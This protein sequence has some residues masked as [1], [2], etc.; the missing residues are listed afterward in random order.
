MSEYADNLVKLQEKVKIVA[1]EDI[2]SDN[3]VLLAK[4]GIELN[5]KICANI[6]KF[7]LLKPLENSIAIENQLNAKSIYDK[8]KG[9]ILT[10]LSINAMHQKIGDKTSLQKCC[11]RVEKFPLIQQKLTVLCIELPTVFDQA[12]QSAYL[13]Y[14]CALIERHEQQNI[15]EYFLAGLVHDIG[16]LHIN[17]KILQKEGALTPDEWSNIQAHPIIAYEILNSIDKFPKV[18]SR[19]VLEHHENLDGTGYPRKKTGQDLSE[20]G[21]LLSLL[22]NVIAIY[23]KKFKTQGRS[24]RS[25]IPVLQINMHSYFPSVSST[26]IGMLKKTPNLPVQSTDSNFARDVIEKSERKQSYIQKTTHVIKETNKELG[27]THNNKD[28]HFIQ[29]AANNIMFIVNSAGLYGSFYLDEGEDLCQDEKQAHYNELADT[30][31]MLEEII[32]QCQFYEKTAGIFVAG[33]PQNPL[34][35]IISGGL[36]KI[37]ALS[38][39]RASGP[40]KRSRT[41]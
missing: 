38:L 13:A 21:Q 34:A 17:H 2:L 40:F 1:T 39:P 12:I 14:A 26:I 37:K 19:A 28:I 15:E 32:Y 31:V 24:L 8:V 10:N 6:L 41:G 36:E 18:V 22:D 33:N 25:V 3:G 29:N 5:K 16:F 11:L 35:K 4:S 23:S 7:K 27:F 30:L 20:L 9:Y